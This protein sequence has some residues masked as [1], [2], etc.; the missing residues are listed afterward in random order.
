QYSACLLVKIQRCEKTN[1]AYGSLKNPRVKRW[2]GNHHK[3]EGISYN[4]TTELYGN[5][6]TSPDIMAPIAQP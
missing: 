2:L 5:Y 1:S 3:T 4:G 6:V